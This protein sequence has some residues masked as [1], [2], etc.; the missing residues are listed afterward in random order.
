MKKLLLL[1]VMLMGMVGFCQELVPVQI[2]TIE[3]E[4]GLVKYSRD[5][6]TLIIDKETS[7]FYEV[8]SPIRF[9]E[10]NVYVFYLKPKNCLDCTTIEA[11]LIGHTV[12]VE[13]TEKNIAAMRAKILKESPKE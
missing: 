9:Q 8:K 11:E 13:Q 3:I 12:A 6:G 7:E 1:A 5:N 2:E 4:N 10:G